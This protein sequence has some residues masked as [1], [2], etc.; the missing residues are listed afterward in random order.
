MPSRIL[1]SWSLVRSLRQW[2]MLAQHHLVQPRNPSL[3][4]N[5]VLSQAQLTR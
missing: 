4:S 3:V 2:G 1:R 5:P